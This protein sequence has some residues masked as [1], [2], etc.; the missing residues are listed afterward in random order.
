MSVLELADALD[1]LNITSGSSS[2]EVQAF[3]DAAEA[4]IARH[5]GPLSSTATT[6]RVVGGGCAL[7]LPVLPAVSLTSV[8]PV[9]DGSPLTL[10][11]LYLS[12][13]AG[14]VTYTSGASF[15]DR[16]YDVVYSA[17]RTTCPDDL[18]MAVRELVRHMWQTQRGPTRRPGSQPSEGTANTVPGAAYMLPFRVSEL[19]APHLQSG[20]A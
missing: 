2:L 18:L 9:D 12:T 7:V 11:D 13:G 19:I 4:V 16:F 6:V 20:F 10:G 3:V 8:T 15:P 17:G 1:H 14:L 5:C